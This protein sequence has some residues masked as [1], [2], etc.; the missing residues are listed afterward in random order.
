MGNRPRGRTPAGVG[1]H[2]SAR[3]PFRYILANWLGVTLLIAALVVLIP[4]HLT[5]L[6]FGVDAIAAV[7]ASAGIG[8][9]VSAEPVGRAA[10]RIGAVRLIRVGSIVMGA[11]V[12]GIGFAAT[13]PMMIA[14]NG[15]V[16]V[17]TSMLRVGSQMV[18]RN[19]ID[20]R[21]RGRVH[22]GQGFIGRVAMLATPVA[23][24]FAWERFT[25]TWSFVLTATAAWSMVVVGGSIVVDPSPTVRAG[26]APITPLLT[27]IRY[28]SGPT[29]FTAARSAR[30]LLLPLVGLELGQT[31]SRIGLLVGLS[32]A[33]DV[34]TAPVSG[35]LMDGR[36][37]LATIIPSFSLTA[38]GFVLLGLAD[39]GWLVG[40]AAVVL[41]LANGLSAGLLL[42][43]G[44][45]LAP[46]GKEGPFLGR[47]GAM[48][49]AGRLLGPF[50]VGLLGELLGLD[51]ASL[52]MAG[53]T[54]IGLACL[55]AFV[56]ETRPAR[57]RPITPR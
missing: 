23:I 18:V 15:M 35:P 5:A 2:L 24:G 9:F 4:L 29:L 36:G 47:F 53:V 33:A 19:R 11:S 48:H 31:A 34:A 54:L 41:G 38:A 10:A 32:A 7:T 52:A 14:L 50:I 37:R 16:G 28:S 40:A 8:G 44:T 1:V 43:L 3:S 45:D 25:S 42:T 46:A 12:I 20:D 21:R 49:D 22:A 17:C 30:G 55:L 13:L 6:G 27:M 26:D 56:G 57:P 39:T 51:I